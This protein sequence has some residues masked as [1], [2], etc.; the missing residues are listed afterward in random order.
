MNHHY[1]SLMCWMARAAYLS[2]YR[3]YTPPA[4]MGFRGGRIP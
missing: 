1:A 2:G 4:I 3:W